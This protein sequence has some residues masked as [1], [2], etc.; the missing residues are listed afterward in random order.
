MESPPPSDE[1]EFDPDVRAVGTSSL[2]A[3][4]RDEP[5]AGKEDHV[6]YIAY[7]SCPSVP[8]GNYDEKVDKVSHNSV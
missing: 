4:A 6:A 5:K 7:E 2:P 3:S 8:S 1:P